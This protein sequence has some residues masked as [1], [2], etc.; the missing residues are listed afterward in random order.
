MRLTH[1][2]V[3]PVCLGLPGALVTS[4]LTG[5]P[6]DDET[7]RWA[8]G[9]DDALAKKLARV[10]LISQRASTSLEQFL[11]AYND[12]RTRDAK[13]GT[14]VIRR[15]ASAFAARWNTWSPCMNMP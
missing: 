9:L 8:A 13:P 4:A 1:T 12:A 3:C 15:P 14:I 7:A 11:R 5:Q 6:P 2:Q 10:G